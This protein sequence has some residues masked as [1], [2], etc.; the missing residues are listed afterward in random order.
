MRIGQLESGRLEIP[1]DFQETIGAQPHDVIELRLVDD[2][3]RLKRAEVASETL[4]Q[5]WLQELYEYFRPFREEAEASG[6]TDDEI[7]EAID[8]AFRSVRSERA[9]GTL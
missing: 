7:N 9:V 4:P 3:I 1:A 6:L 5:P 2:E 8:E